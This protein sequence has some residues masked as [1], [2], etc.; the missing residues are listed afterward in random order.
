MRYGFLYSGYKVHF[1]FWEA[2]VIL[3]KVAVKAVSVVL[4]HSEPMQ[5]VMAANTVIVSML[6]LQLNYQPYESARIN[7]IETLS[8]VAN[9]LTLTLGAFFNGQNSAVVR[10]LL[11][12]SI[13]GA[14]CAFL[15]YWVRSLVL[16]ST[17]CRRFRRKRV[18]AQTTDLDQ[19]I[20]PC[21]P[22]REIECT[23]IP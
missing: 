8:M 19:S 14:N 18:Q 10:N 5:R 6:A 21:K 20:S 22:P 11:F 12:A 7:R 9:F 16:A 13:V 23:Q 15:I 17:L 1:F 3:R 2:L 4:S